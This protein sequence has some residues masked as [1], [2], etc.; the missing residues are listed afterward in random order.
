[1]FYKITDD[2]SACGKC[3]LECSAI[4]ISRSDDIYVIDPDKC[5]GCGA[6]LIVCPVNAIQPA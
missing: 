2:C 3:V 4:A 1:M 6:C 5:S